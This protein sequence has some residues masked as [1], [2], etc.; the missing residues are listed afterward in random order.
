LKGEDI[1]A[2]EEFSFGNFNKIQDVPFD[3]VTYIIGK[4]DNRIEALY[5][6]YISWLKIKSSEEKISH[7][8][9]V[10]KAWW[11]KLLGV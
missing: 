10:K 2:E 11:Q 6:Q 4:W 7:P 1:V 5:Q 3:S 8:V 9:V